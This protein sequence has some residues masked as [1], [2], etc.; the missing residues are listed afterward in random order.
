MA[1]I[2]V[3]LNPDRTQGGILTIID[4][5]GAI[6]GNGLS[7]LAKAA[8]DDATA[9]GNPLADPTMA[10]GDTPTGTYNITGMPGFVFPYNNLH[11]Y[12]PNGVIQLD[13]LSG[14]AAVAKANGRF[15]FLFH[16]GDPGPGGALR[17]TNGC[18]RL[19]NDEMAYL[20]DQINQLYPTDQVTT[21]E[22]SEVG[23][24][25]TIICDSNSS[26]GEGDPPPGF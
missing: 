11:S 21:V 14:Q 3:Q 4:S 15:G 7:V 9:H 20:K 23:V 8:V 26:C 5:T 22:V 2:R 1:K 17:R 24:S 6:V 13:P 10:Y 16:G 19:Q 25:S 18:M 12:G